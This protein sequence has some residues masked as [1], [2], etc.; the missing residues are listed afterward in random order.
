VADGGGELDPRHG[1]SREAGPGGGERLTGVVPGGDLQER[2]DE[3][4]G[5]EE[6]VLDENEALPPARDAGGEPHGDG[7]LPRTAPGE[8]LGA[9][10]GPRQA[11]SR[12]GARLAAGRARKAD[13]RPEL[14]QRLVVVSRRSWVQ[15]GG[16]GGFDRGAG[17]SRAW[18]AGNRL[19]PR[20]DARHVSVQGCHGDAECDGGE[21]GRGVRADARKGAQLLDR[22]GDGAAAFRDEAGRAMEVSRPGVVAEAAPFRQDFL[23]PGGREGRDGRE[24]VEKPL[25]ARDS[26]GDRRLLEDRLGNPDGPRVAGPPE[27]KVAALAPVPLQERGAEGRQA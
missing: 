27:R 20:E 8:G 13:E 17:G 19:E 1:A 11:R 3:V 21:G 15:E 9:S 10:R 12:E 18:V 6:G 26:G 24:A 14:H 7:G 25:P 2:D 16:C 23:F 4:A 22:T 5:D